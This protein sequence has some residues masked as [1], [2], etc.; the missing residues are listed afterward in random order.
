M[1][2]IAGDCDDTER[3]VNPVAIEICDGIDNN[4]DLFI[5]E[6]DENLDV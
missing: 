2:Q 5:D 4:C 6:D 1:V 3:F